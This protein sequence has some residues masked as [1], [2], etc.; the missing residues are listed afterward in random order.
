MPRA[1]AEHDTGAPPE[2]RGLNQHAYAEIRRRILEGE[3]LPSSPLS[4]HQ[5]AAALQL[6]RTPVRE[7]IKRLEKE[8]LVRSIP[9]RGT[10][11][12]ELTAHDILEIYQVRERLE[13]LAARI[14][15]ELMSPADVAALEQEIAFSEQC[16]TEGRTGETLES[17]ARFHKH[18][19]TATQNQRLGAILATLDDQMYRIRVLLPGAAGWQAE[20]T[21]EHHTIVARISARDGD[22]AEQAME[23]H[24]RASCDRAVRLAL[25][26]QR[27]YVR[28][29]A[30]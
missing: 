16:A 23:Q 4:E 24:L 10:F 7:A 22:G 29:S 30:T 19:I 11:I 26:I 28:P 21:Q 25:P 13:S 20:A 8:G 2:E 12:T 1:R 6:S 9:S 14:A 15:A 3:L 18:I 5:L 17:D 27:R